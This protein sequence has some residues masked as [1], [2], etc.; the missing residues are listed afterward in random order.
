MKALKKSAMR[1]QGVFLVAA[2]SLLIPVLVHMTSRSVNGGYVRGGVSME[3]QIQMLSFCVFE[4]TI[5]IFWPSMMKMRSQYVPDEK[6]STVINCFRIPVN[7]IVCL[8]LFNVSNMK[9]DT[10]F[11]MCAFFLLVCA[12]LQRRLCKG[13]DMKLLDV[14]S[15]KPPLIVIRSQFRDIQKSP[16]KTL[17]RSAPNLEKNG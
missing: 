6:L 1:V 8:V 4:A 3:A 10:I 2:I 11:A 5:G 15:P 13:V 7:L 9:L 14:K 16:T 12:A 17:V